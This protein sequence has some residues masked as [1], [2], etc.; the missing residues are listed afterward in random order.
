MRVKAETLAI[1]TTAVELLSEIVPQTIRER[2]RKVLPFL[3]KA[4]NPFGQLL[5]TLTSH[6]IVACARCAAHADKIEGLEER[7]KLLE[8]KL[9]EEGDV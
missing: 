5:N 1:A 8:H 2:T 7:I 4:S 6:V 9:N 3:S